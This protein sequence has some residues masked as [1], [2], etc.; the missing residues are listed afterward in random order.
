MQFIETENFG[1]SQSLKFQDPSSTFPRLRKCFSLMQLGG[2]PGLQETL[3]FEESSARVAAL[4][5]PT[6]ITPWDL[7]LKNYAHPE[8]GPVWRDLELKN[9]AQSELGPDLARSELTH[10]CN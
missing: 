1:K 5:E 9:Y 3:G 8:Q 6:L 2:R 7:A 10:S 4:C